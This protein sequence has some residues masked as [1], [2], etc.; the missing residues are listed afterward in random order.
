MSQVKALKDF[1][2]P[3][4]S[5]IHVVGT[6]FDLP[7]ENLVDFAVGM[8]HLEVVEEVVEPP[9]EETPAKSAKSAKSAPVEAK[10]TKTELSSGFDG[11]KDAS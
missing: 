5:V 7:D 3:Y 9:P 6:E 4:A 2:D 10:P 8:G 1:L 11:G